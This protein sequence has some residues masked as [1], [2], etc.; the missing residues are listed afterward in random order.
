MN[1]DQTKKKEQSQE[2]ALIARSPEAFPDLMIYPAGWDLESP[3]TN[4]KNGSA[5]RKRG[6]M[7]TFPK[8]TDAML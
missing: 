5:A 7:L 8:T 2:T 6:K 1:T 3:S 4:G